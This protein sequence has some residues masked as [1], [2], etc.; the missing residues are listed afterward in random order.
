MRK[1]KG[2]SEPRT[3]EGC[4][5][6]VKVPPNRFESFRA[7]SRECLW[8]LT[9][10]DRIPLK[11]AICTKPFEVIPVRAKTA[12][13][14]SRRCYYKAK[15]GSIDLPC[16]ICGTTFRTSP[17]RNN[18]TCSRQCSGKRRRQSTLSNGGYKSFSQKHGFVA[19]EKCERCGWKV[20]CALVVHHKDRNKQNNRSENLE[21]LCWNCHMV[22]HWAASDGPFVRFKPKGPRRGS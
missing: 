7:C 2:K 20:K 18:F 10:K 9:Q 14:C 4:G 8:K 19:V 11:C 12:K 1:E 22:E 6:I 5:T 3:C 13:Y 15:Y 16:A 21:V 17:S